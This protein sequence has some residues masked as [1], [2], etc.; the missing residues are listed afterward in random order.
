MLEKRDWKRVLSNAK[1]KNETVWD[2]SVRLG[3]Y[4]STV[5]SA[6]KRHKIKLRYDRPDMV[7]R[8]KRPA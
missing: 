4:Y 2:V 8:L 6:A 5:Y 7:R 3:E 1:G